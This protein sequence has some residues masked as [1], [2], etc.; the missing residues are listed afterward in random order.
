MILFGHGSPVSLYFDSIIG[1]KEHFQVLFDRLR[2][3]EQLA[4][5]H[6]AQSANASLHDNSR[7]SPALTIPLRRDREGVCAANFAACLYKTRNNKKGNKK[8]RVRN[9]PYGSPICVHFFTQSVLFI[10][11]HLCFKKS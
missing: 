9:P 4:F 8:R 11:V 3:L 5:F 1:E 10:R 2:A 7:P 6:H